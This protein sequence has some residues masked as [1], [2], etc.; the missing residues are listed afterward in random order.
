MQ[1][2][3]AAQLLELPVCGRVSIAL[4]GISGLQG[5]YLKLTYGN[6]EKEPLGPA[7][8][9]QDPKYVPSS[10]VGNLGPFGVV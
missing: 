5:F 2:L 9:A 7:K 3:L 4:A 8:V 10:R 6:Y 1:F